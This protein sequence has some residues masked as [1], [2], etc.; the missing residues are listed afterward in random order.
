MCLL[1]EH[2]RIVCSSISSGGDLHVSQPFGYVV[3]RRL[4]CD[5]LCSRCWRLEQALFRLERLR[6]ITGVVSGKEQVVHRYR[7][8]VTRA[9]TLS[10]VFGVHYFVGH[11]A[12]LH[13]CGQRE[14]SLIHIGSAA[15]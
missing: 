6:P 5:A 14:D 3:G 12:R 4:S 1:Y 15:A 7:F 2:R 10:R 13:G 11:L 8:G 9:V